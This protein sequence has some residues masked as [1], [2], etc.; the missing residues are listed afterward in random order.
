[1]TNQSVRHTPSKDHLYGLYDPE[2]EGYTFHKTAKERDEYAEQTIKTYL[3]DGLWFDEVTNIFAF[4]ATHQATQ[5][6]T[7]ERKGE[8]D[9]DG[10]DENDEHWPDNDI[11][12]KCNYALEPIKEPQP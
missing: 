7:I 4:E 6:D 2:G 1:M 9:E 3:D 11:D 8:L 12:Y 10:C 5:V